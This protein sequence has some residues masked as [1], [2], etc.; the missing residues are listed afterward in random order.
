[1]K[2]LFGLLLILNVGFFLWQFNKTEQPTFTAPA[3]VSQDN[4]KRLI[5]LR[6]LDA[7]LAKM[8]PPAPATTPNDSPIPVSPADAAVPAS[9]ENPSAP[10]PT[11]F[12]SNTTQPGTEPSTPTGVQ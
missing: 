10:P 6:E 11:P 7:E 2:W 5:L 9:P 12:S 4:S 3:S 8:P 1:M